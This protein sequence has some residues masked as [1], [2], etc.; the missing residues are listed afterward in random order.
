MGGAVA[1]GGMT[2]V[3]CSH[4]AFPF[5]WSVALDKF[6]GVGQ[7]IRIFLLFSECVVKLRSKSFTSLYCHQQCIEVS[8]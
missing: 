2:F 3:M 7:R 8:V 4:L 6:P 5:I 1:I